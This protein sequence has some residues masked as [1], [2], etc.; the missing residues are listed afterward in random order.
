MKKVSFKIANALK[1]AGYPQGNTELCYLTADLGQCT[2]GQVVNNIDGMWTI[3]TKD[4]VD[5]PTYLEVWLWLWREK[6]MTIDIIALSHGSC[7]AFGWQFG[8]RINSKV[9]F[10]DPEDA[11][12]S[13]IDDIV[14]NNLIK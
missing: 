8:E 10:N 5:I 6:Q 3:L 2:K 4:L 1:E 7:G 9:K 13:A 12:I 14:E 11:I